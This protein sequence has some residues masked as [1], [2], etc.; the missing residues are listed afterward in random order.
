VKSNK[1]RGPV[2]Q[3]SSYGIVP[4]SLGQNLL[5]DF[6]FA[7]FLPN[8]FG[9]QVENWASH[10]IAPQKS[11]GPDTAA[12]GYHFNQWCDPLVLC[13]VDYRSMPDLTL[14]SSLAQT[15][16]KIPKKSVQSPIHPFTSIFFSMASTYVCRTS[17]LLF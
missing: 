13:P 7:P 17:P 12:F 10:S 5:S 8:L 6:Q 9:L 14:E 15:A 11:D 16:A 4:L 1:Y 2:G 3:G